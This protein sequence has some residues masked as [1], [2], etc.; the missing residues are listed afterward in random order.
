[1]R[2]RACKRLADELCFFF[3]I[4]LFSFKNGFLLFIIFHSKIKKGRR[5]IFFFFFIFSKIFILFCH[6]LIFKSK[7]RF[8]IRFVVG[9][10][11]LLPLCA[12]IHAYLSLSLSPV[13]HSLAHSLSRSH[14]L[15]RTHLHTH[16]CTFIFYQLSHIRSFLDLN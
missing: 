11:L 14:S 12:S 4:C 13:S 2:Q 5:S 9:F 6:F 1:M 7:T 16:A 15:T 8:R 3:F 10:S